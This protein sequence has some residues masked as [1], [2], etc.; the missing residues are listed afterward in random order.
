MD[1]ELR[2]GVLVL[3]GGKPES[4]LAS[5]AWQLA[6]LRMT[7]LARSLRHRLGDGVTVRQVQYRLRG[8]NGAQ[9]DALRDARMALEDIREEFDAA[10]IVVVGHSMGA[11]VAVHL[12]A[13]GDVGAVVALAPW[14]PRNDADL[15]PT[16]CRLLVLHGTADTRTD[17]G[18]SRAQTRHARDRGVDAQWVAMVD[19]DHSM[20]RDWQRWHRLTAEFAAVQLA[21]RLP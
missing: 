19:A 14:W 5:R 2:G 17:P 9:F 8:W 10:K 4:T 21:E 11:R 15:V 12:A 18:S 20:I 1:N 16:S 6:N 13:D 3:P 7:L